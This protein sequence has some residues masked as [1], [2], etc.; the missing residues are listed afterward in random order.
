MAA[1][2]QRSD[3]QAKPRGVVLPLVVPVRKKVDDLVRGASGGEHVRGRSI[4]IGVPSNGAL[5][6]EEM[7]IAE[8]GERQPVLDALR[9][10]TVLCEPGDGPDRAGRVKK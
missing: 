3:A 8:A 9:L 5:V 1:A 7:I 10:L 2:H 4:D 6:G